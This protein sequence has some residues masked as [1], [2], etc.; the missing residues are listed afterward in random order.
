MPLSVLSKR[1]EYLQANYQ[2]DLQ[3][4]EKQF[5]RQFEPLDRLFGK[6]KELEGVQRK[7]EEEGFAEDSPEPAKKR[8]NALNSRSKVSNNYTGGARDLSK[9]KK[10]MSPMKIKSKTGN[11]FYPRAGGRVTADKLKPKYWIKS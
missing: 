10:S 2:R 4:L 7:L 11:H 6:K 3:E 1:L 5:K 8:A 9:G